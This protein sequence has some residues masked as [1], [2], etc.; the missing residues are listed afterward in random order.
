M[1][2]YDV[3]AAMPQVVNRV[4]PWSR[5]AAHVTE[6]QVQVYRGTFLFPLH[7]EPAGV[8]PAQPHSD[9]REDP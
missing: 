4:R 3:W 8:E 9:W 5:I 7:V 2:T 1:L 6:E